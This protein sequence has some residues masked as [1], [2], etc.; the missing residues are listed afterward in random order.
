MSNESKIYEITR[1]MRDDQVIKGDV[2]HAANMV[3]AML[4]E[5]YVAPITRAIAAENKKARKN[6]CKE[7]KL[8]EVVK[9]FVDSGQHESLDRAIDALHMAE[10][11]RG[12]SAQMPKHSYGPMKREMMAAGFESGNG[13][14]REDGV[15][16]VDERCAGHKGQRPL[17][18]IF[19]V[20][21]M[22]M[23]LEGGR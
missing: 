10:T 2:N 20:M 9:S 19:A 18:P 23:M 11:L 6:P 22:T 17:M 4:K 8:L 21:A 5:K 15:Y 3:K 16:D 1:M 13:S 14:I 12:L 7:A